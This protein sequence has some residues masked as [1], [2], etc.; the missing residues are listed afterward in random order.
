MSSWA[1]GSID[2]ILPVVPGANREKK[3]KS[4]MAENCTTVVIFP[5]HLMLSTVIM[6]IINNCQ[7]IPRWRN[8]LSFVTVF[9]LLTSLFRRM[10]SHPVLLMTMNVPER[11]V[12]NTA[13]PTHGKMKCCL[14]LEFRVILVRKPHEHEVPTL[15]SFGAGLLFDLILTAK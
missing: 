2:S 3:K 1:T 7:L 9:Y 5:Q 10:S 13:D 14:V 8:R 12:Y 15:F 11:N 4:N 6:N